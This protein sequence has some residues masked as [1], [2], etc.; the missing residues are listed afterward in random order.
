MIGKNRELDEDV[1]QG[2]FNDMDTNFIKN[3]P[4][5]T[6]VSKDRMI[7]PHA[8]DGRVTVKSVIHQLK[9]QRKDKA[10]G[11]SSNE[12]VWRVICK[13]NTIPQVKKFM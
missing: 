7:S 1:I 10:H 2:S 8:K 12:N 4:L 3:M 5:R 13:V 9:E 11:M 6:E